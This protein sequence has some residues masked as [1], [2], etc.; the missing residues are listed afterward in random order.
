M[1]FGSGLPRFI[2]SFTFQP[3][4]VVMEV[5]RGTEGQLVV[6][7][8]AG[9]RKIA[10]W[11]ETVDFVSTMPDTTH[12]CDFVHGHTPYA[13]NSVDV[14]ISTGVLEH[15]EDDRLF[16]AEIHRILK[17]GGLVHIELPFLQQY[18]E[19]PID[20]RRLTLP[21]LRQFLTDAGFDVVQSGVH[22]GPTVTLL[23]LISWWFNLVF[24]GRSLFRRALA[25]GV[26]AG[27]SVVAWPLRYLD[28][29]LIRKPN[30]HKLAF[31]I[32]ATAKK[33]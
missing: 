4:T 9:G 5:V 30:A 26:F 14:V 15:V 25:T 3:K 11:V 32:Y 2:P 27:F 16:I 23:T 24:E 19:D 21:G 22:I 1:P 31:G 29:W 33:R 10:P 12:V 13:D 17:P 18:H 6:D 7:L 28:L 8:G 20:Y